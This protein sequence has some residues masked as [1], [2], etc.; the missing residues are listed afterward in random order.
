MIALLKLM[1]AA[2]RPMYHRVDYKPDNRFSRRW[3]LK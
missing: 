2:H 3:A 1:L